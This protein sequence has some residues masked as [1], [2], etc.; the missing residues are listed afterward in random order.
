M[1]HR[2]LQLLVLSSAL[3][4]TSFAQVAVYSFTGNVYTATSSNANI[5]AGAF[6]GS[7]TTSL[8][9]GT[10]VY[11]AGSGSYAISM[12]GFTGTAPGTSYFSVTLTPN[13]GYQL[14]IAS[15]SFGSRST[16]TGPTAF[17]IRSS[18]DNYAANLAS[19]SLTNDG[20]WYSS[21]SI[22]ITLS[23]VTTAT[24]LR[25]Y[26]S[27]ASSAAGTLRLDD[28]SFAGSVTP[29]PEPSTYAAIFGTLALVGVALH[30]RR[31]KVRPN[32]TV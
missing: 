31:A 15:L 8:T 18:A 6:G 7:G 17:A 23:A 20:S 12:S 11:S 28:I 29:I 21:G 13:S 25:I 9:N 16:S 4:A 3:V 10:P 30:R 26:G 19:G 1:I 2:L 22:S 5:T 24:T 32:A 27:G 14:D